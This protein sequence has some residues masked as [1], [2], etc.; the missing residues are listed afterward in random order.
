[1][2][3]R[4]SWLLNGLHQGV[5]GTR[6]AGSSVIHQAFQGRVLVTTRQRKTAAVK[7]KEE[8]LRQAAGDF[9]QAEADAEAEAAEEDDKEGMT[10]WSREE[11]EVPF[12]VLSLEIPPTPL[13]KDSQGGN[14]IPQVTSVLRVW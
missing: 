12:L 7:R 4:V 2:H 11:A 10:D 5:G 14:V 8:E 1:M 13:F 9:T 6:K 3:A